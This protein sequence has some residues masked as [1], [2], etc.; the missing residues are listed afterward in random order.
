MKIKI[1][2][3]IMLVIVSACGRKA[4]NKR[5]EE[6]S[7]EPSVYKGLS[8][9]LEEC[10]NTSEVY[11]EEDKAFAVFDFD[12]TT[13]MN[14]VEYSLF[15]Y[16]IENLKFDFSPEELHKRL[17]DSPVSPDFKLNAGDGRIITAGDLAD[18]IYEAY[19]ELYGKPLDEITNTDAYKDYRAKIRYMYDALD[20]VMP[21]ADV[22]AWLFNIIAVGSTGEEIQAL[23]R[24]S[25]YSAIAKAQVKKETWTSTGSGKTGKISVEI[26]DGIVITP[27]IKDLYAKLEANG[28]IPYIVSASPEDVVEAVVTDGGIGITVPAERVFGMRY[29]KDSLGRYLKKRVQGYPSTWGEGKTAAIIKYIAPLHGGKGPVLVAGDSNGDYNMLVDFPDMKAGLIFNR[30][31]SGPLRTLYNQ[32]PKYL[33]QRRD[34]F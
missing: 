7:W 31:E 18:D 12:N 22:S 3:I 23:T 14:D 20:D 34:S 10:G 13:I 15:A 4:E 5:L 33:L 27:D 26:E 28:I 9:V 29:E 2:A 32:Q 1:F 17:I 24:E 30:N 25:T 6:G 16:I 21:S 19:K 8:A 11:N